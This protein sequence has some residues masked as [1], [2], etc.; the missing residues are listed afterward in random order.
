MIVIER[1]EKKPGIFIGARMYRLVLNDQGL[2]ILELGKAMGARNKKNAL[3]DIVLDKIQE[4]REK[5]HAEKETELGSADLNL[6][7]DNKKNFL[8]K[9]TDVKEVKTSHMDYYPKLDIKS[10]VVKISLH[11]SIEDVERVKKIAE[12]LRSA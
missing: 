1:C 4:N 7:V 8:V 2:Y 12:Y 3:A 9:N 11:F 6:V 10:G 5:Q